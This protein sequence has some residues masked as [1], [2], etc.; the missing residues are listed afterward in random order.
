MAATQ[1]TKLPN[2][3]RVRRK[4]AILSSQ[5]GDTE[6]EIKSP[7]GRVASCFDTYLLCGFSA[8]LAKPKVLRQGS[9]R[10]LWE[11][12]RHGVTLLSRRS[13]R[14]VGLDL[15]CEELK[16]RSIFSAIIL[17]IRSLNCRD[18]Y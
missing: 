18:Q 12:A 1:R 10:G 16:T 8:R 3:E 13:S 14:V 9:G 5:P 2:G 15:P 17:F 7:S 11:K 4:C 6:A